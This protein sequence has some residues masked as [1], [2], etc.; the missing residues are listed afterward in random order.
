MNNLGKMHPTNTL[1]NENLLSMPALIIYQLNLTIFKIINNPTSINNGILIFF[2]NTNDTRTPAGNLIPT[3]FPRLEII[4]R[5]FFYAGMQSYNNLPSDIQKSG[6]ISEFKKKIK[7][8][9]K[10]KSEF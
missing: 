10:D 1:F 8:W 4:K 2:Q 7:E 5:S 6:T 9:L 3:I